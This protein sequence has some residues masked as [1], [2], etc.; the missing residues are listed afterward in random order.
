MQIPTPTSD[1]KIDPTIVE[2]K[3]PTAPAPEP[4]QPEI[5]PADIETKPSTPEP[6]PDDFAPKPEIPAP[7]APGTP[8][9]GSEPPAPIEPVSP[10]VKKLSSETSAQLIAGFEDSLQQLVLPGLYTKYIFSTAE[11]TRIRELK[12]KK[13]ADP[14]FKPGNDKDDELLSRYK[15]YQELKELLPFEKDEKQRLIETWDAIIKENPKLALSPW[16]ALIMVH[17][18]LFGPRLMPILSRLSF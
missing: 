9:P 10:L 12:S 5:K 11:K 8:A 16:T 14:N 2:L 4:N 1:L 3:Q 18:E 13:L 6:N 7:A 15:D 17:A